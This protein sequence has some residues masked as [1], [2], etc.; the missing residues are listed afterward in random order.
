MQRIAGL[1]RS[2][3]MAFLKT[4]YSVLAGFVGI[5]FVV[6]VLFLPQNALMTGV[7]FVVGAVLSACAGWIGMRTAT[8]C[9]RTD[10][11]RRHD[12]SVGSPARCILE[13]GRHGT[14]GGGPWHVRNR[15]AVLPVRRSVGERSH[16]DGTAFRLFARCIVNRAVCLVWVVAF[17][18]RR[19]TSRATCRARS[20]PASRRTTRA[21]PRPS[22]TALVTTWGTSPG[23]AP[24]SSSP[25][26]GSIIASIALAWAL[27]APAATALWGVDDAS[28][29]Q[30]QGSLVL[31][32]ILLAG[33]GILASILGTF[34]V[35]TDDESK[36]GGALH[37]GLLVASALVLGGGLAGWSWCWEFHSKFS[38]AWSSGWRLAW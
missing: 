38:G 27:T 8:G 36:I 9:R 35:N 28:F 34:A 19:Q 10:H 5:M 13:W 14:Y 37:R 32:P 20:R 4:E 24:T 18:P 1:I 22:R 23:W 12:E 2:G 31:F 6:L 33:V 3:A 21:T 16:R 25:Y 11:V 17:T 7:S 29:S 26:V 15:D 30:V